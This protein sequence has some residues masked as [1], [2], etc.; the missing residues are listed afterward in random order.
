MKPFTAE[1]FVRIVTKWTGYILSGLT[2]LAFLGGCAVAPPKTV[3][4]QDISQ[5]FEEGTII[6]AEL[7]APISVK[8]LFKDL[9]TS[10]VIY[11]GENHT[12]QAH[13]AIQLE[14][15]KAVFE[16]NS[17]M[18]IGMEMFDQSYQDVLD[19]WSAG[20]LDQ[21]EFLRKVHWYANW[22]F[23]FSLYGGILN[24]IKE[25][26]IRLVGLNIPFH[27]PAKIRVGGIEN[28]RDYEKQ[29]LPEEIDTSKT[30]HREYLKEIFSHHHFKS[31]VEF[32]DFYMAQSAWEDAMAAMVSKYLKDDRM[33]VLAGNG[34]IQFKY[35]IPDRAFSRTGAYFRTIY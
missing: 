1:G 20:G 19:L 34:H 10:Q 21:K 25:N 26:H 3:I 27:I 11:V 5:A 6:S 32:E 33:V 15:I 9:E 30:A 8:E 18:V 24:F 28:L 22:R 16:K 35:G 23:D 13:H 7:G 14:V 29:Y 4:I 17:Q 12:N 2:M 31:S